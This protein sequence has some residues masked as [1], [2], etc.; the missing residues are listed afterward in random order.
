MEKTDFLVIGAGAVGLA[1]AQTLAERKPDRSVIVAERHPAFGQETSS[2][3]SEVIHAGIYYPQG[4]LKARLCVRGRELIYD[5][6]VKHRLPHQRLGK[7]IVAAVRDEEALLGKLLETA[8]GNGVTDAA[9]MTSAQVSALEPEVASVAAIHSPSTGI[10]DTHAYMKKLEALG[11]ERGVMYAYG[12]EARRI[13]RTPDGFRVTLKDADGQ[14][15]EIGAG[16]VVNCAGLSSDK[17]AESAGIDLDQADYRLHLSKGEYF[18]VHGLPRWLIKRLVYPVPGTTSLGVHIVLDLDGGFKLGPNA[19]WTDGIDY[20]VDPAHGDEMFAAARRYLPRLTRES[21]E[22]DMAGIRAKLQKP[23]QL[24]RDFVIVN[25]KGRGL[26]GLI[27]CIGIE[28]PG[29]TSSLAIAEYVAGL[30]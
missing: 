12:C 24:F 7:L 29:L 6:L 14:D 21:L 1:I 19:V 27:D 30:V 15:L 25:E 9:L 4:S 20:T 23:G 11:K 17:V 8:H 22:P 18:K 26:P 13:E 16:V 3:N 10:F 28:S 2:R 5:F